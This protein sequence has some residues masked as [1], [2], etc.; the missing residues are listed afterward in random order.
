MPPDRQPRDDN[1]LFIDC[2]PLG[3]RPRHHYQ[4]GDTRHIDIVLSSLGIFPPQGWKL[5]VRLSLSGQYLRIFPMAFLR[6][7]RRLLMTAL[8]MIIR[9]RIVIQTY[10]KT[11]LMTRPPR[12]PLCYVLG[13]DHPGVLDT[14]D[15]KLQILLSVCVRQ[16][17]KI[18]S[19]L[20]NCP[21]TL[22]KLT[23]CLG[24]VGLAGLHSFWDF[25]EAALCP[26]VA[27]FKGVRT[28]RGPDRLPSNASPEA[29]QAAGLPPAHEGSPG[30]REP[31]Q[32][33]PPSLHA[34]PPTQEELAAQ[35][36]PFQAT[37][38]VLAPS[39]SSEIVKI[40]LSAPCTVNQ[41]LDAVELGRPDARQDL[42]GELTPVLPQ[43]FEDHAV[44]IAAP[45]WSLTTRVVCLHIDFPQPRLFSV[46]VPHRL[47]RESICLLAECPLGID[48]CVYV[49]NSWLA[50]RQGEFALFNHGDLVTLAP[51]NIL[52]RPGVDLQTML[53]S[54]RPWAANP[55]VVLGPPGCHFNIL[56]D[57][58]PVRL[59]LTDFGRQAF[60]G[61][62]ETALQADPLRLSLI[63]PLPAIEDFMHKGFHCERTVL[64]TE[65]ISRIPVPPG[66]VQPRRTAFFI[67]GRPLLLG[68]FWRFAPG[69]Q[70]DVT[71]LIEE[72]AHRVS[73]PFV[74][75]VTGGTPMHYVD[76]T[77]HHIC[78]GQVV[79]LTP[80]CPA[81]NDE[82]SS[83]PLLSDG[84]E[85]SSS[86]SSGHSSPSSPSEHTQRTDN[87]AAPDDPSAAGSES[88]RSPGRSAEDRSRSP[89][90][91]G[92]GGEWHLLTSWLCL[93][94][95]LWLAAAPLTTTWPYMCNG[96]FLHDVFREDELLRT[97]VDQFFVLCAGLAYHLAALAR[98]LSST[99]SVVCAL[100][101]AIQLGCVRPGTIRSFPSLGFAVGVFLAFSVACEAVQLGASRGGVPDLAHPEPARL[102]PHL[103]IAVEARVD[104]DLSSLCRPTV[105]KARP[106]PTPCRSTADPPETA[107]HAAYFT[108]ADDSESEAEEDEAPR[109][110]TPTPDGPD[111]LDCTLDGPS[112][113]EWEIFGRAPV[114]SR[115]SSLSS[116]TLL[117]LAAARADCFA[118]ALASA[119]L[120]VLCEA[121]PPTCWQADVVCASSPGALPTAVRPGRILTL[122]DKLPAS[123]LSRSPFQ[124]TAW[125]AR[126]K[127]CV[128]DLDGT[129]RVGNVPVPF[130]WRQFAQLFAAGADLVDLTTA[131]A[132]CPALRQWSRPGL[133]A[134]LSSACQAF[135]PDDIVCFTDGSYTAVAEG[136][137]LCG[138]ACVLFHTG[139]Q[140]LR[141]LYGSFPAFLA[142]SD[143]CPSPFQGEAAGLLAAALATTATAAY[144]S[145]HFLSDCI[146]ALGIAE[147]VCHSAPGSVAQAMR[148]AHWLR[149]QCTPGTDSYSH[150]RGHQ[151]HIG[152]EVADLLAKAAAS[153]ATPSCGLRTPTH[154]LCAWLGAGAPYLPWAGLAILSATG[155]S[156]LPPC[157]AT[158][159]GNDQDHA[160]LTCCALLEPFIP[161]GAIPDSEDFAGHPK[162]PDVAASPGSWTMSLALATFNTLSLGSSAEQEGTP[163]AVTEGLA[164][165]PARAVLLA[166]QLIDHGIHVACL[167][168]TRAEAGLTK[169]GGFLRFASGAIRGQWG[170]EWWF[171]E[172]HPLGLQS[173]DSPTFR[174]KHFAVVF[175][176]ARRLFV[177][178]VC[179]PIRILFIGVHAP[180]RATEA[181]ALLSWW[182]QT[183]KL[184]KTHCRDE[185]VVFAGDCNAA[186][187]SIGSNHIGPH[188]AEPE[189][190]AGEQLHDILRYI[191]GCLPASIPELHSGPTHTYT[192]KR[193]GGLARIDYL[194]VPRSWLR[195]CCKS[196][197]APGIHAAHSCPDHVAL[198]LHIQLPIQGPSAVPALR[199]R[200]FCASDILAPA[201]ADALA[202][203]LSA[204]PPVPWNI[205][206]HAHAAILVSCV[207]R[208]LTNLKQKSGPRQHRS[209]LKP[210][211]W[212]LQRQVASA[213]G[214]LHRLQHQLRSQRLAV[215]FD[216][217]CG[218]RDASAPH[219]GAAWWKQADVAIAAHQAVLRQWC[220]Q[221]RLACRNDRADH[222]SQL[223]DKISTGPSGEIF[224]NLHAL[225]SHKRRKP[226][227]AEPLPA[228]RLE[229]GTLCA[230]GDQVLARWRRHF[231]GLEAGIELSVPALVD[232]VHQ[233]IHEDNADSSPWP[234]PE[235]LLDLPT[236]AD[237]QRLLVQAKANKAPGADGLPSELGRQFSRQLAP[238]LH[239]LALKTAL[240]GCEPIGFKS[241]KAVWFFKGKGSMS[242]CSS[243][244]AILLLPVW[245]KILHQSLR[246]PLKSHFQANSPELQLGGKSGISVVFGSHLI[247]GAA[248]YAASQGRTH[249]TLFT[250]IASAF[251]TVIQQLVAR[252]GSQTVDASAFRQTTQGLRLS[253]EE[254]EALRQH[255]AAPTAMSS[256]GASPWL[257]ALTSRYQA[258]N[259]FMLKGDDKVVE[260]SRGSRP[261]SSW[262]DLVFAEVITRVLHRRDALRDA[263]F[264][265]SEPVR[266]PWDGER[267]LD[268]VPPS[269]ADLSLDNVVWAD[270]VA[271]PRLT[272]PAQAA[273][274]LAF[275]TSCLVDSFKEFGFSLAFGP[276][277]TA[278]VLHLLGAGSRTAK[279]HIFGS[280]GLAGAVPVVF[281]NG[282]VRLPL[283]HSYRHLGTQQ[284]PGGGLSAEIRYRI[285][286][287]RAS[288]AEGRRKVYKVSQISA[289]RKSHILCAT[290]LAKLFHGA[291]SWGPLSQCERRLLQ[292][293]LWSFYRP[294]LGIKHSDD[295]HVDTFSCL[296]LLELPSLDT[297]M[298]FHRLTYFRQVVSSAPPAVW[299]VLR[300][301]RAH[302]SLV[303]EETQLNAEQAGEETATQLLGLAPELRQSLVHGCS[304]SSL[305]LAESAAKFDVFVVSMF[306]ETSTMHRCFTVS[307]SVWDEVCIPC[308]RAFANRT[309]FARLAGSASLRLDA[310]GDICSPTPT[311]FPSGVLFSLEELGLG[312]RTD[313]SLGLL[314]ELSA[315][316][317]PSSGLVWDIVAGYVEP[318]TVLRATVQEWS[319][320]PEATPD[321]VSVC[322][323]ILLL[324]D[325]DLLADS[326]QPLTA[327]GRTISE[328]V[329]DW[330]LPGAGPLVC[331]LPRQAFLLATPPS[332]HLSP[333]TPRSMRLRDATGYAVW[334]ED[335]CRVLASLVEASQVR[336][337]NLHC[338]GIGD[339]LGPAA[340]WMRAVGF[341]VGPDDISTPV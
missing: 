279:R 249:F 171:R 217:W 324:L 100:C 131:S 45:I 141:F 291:G 302:A 296:A 338:P 205:S 97:S 203:G 127:S 331:G 169:V 233:G 170:T 84:E 66:R 266:L 232:R 192:H 244:R 29:R 82:V 333:W 286:Q 189:D 96:A 234:L 159:L 218:R 241:G 115:H 33:P 177:R 56:T 246:P 3:E 242:D 37:I 102:S 105:P 191:D 20:E 121:F 158:N 227:R 301:D 101:I 320:A 226:Y 59:T 311:A 260:T 21:L 28:H 51:A 78:S 6:M 83:P 68:L 318:L 188:G 157:N 176:D 220:A 304:C 147:G 116:C 140:S 181:E 120:E 132:F 280:S 103:A 164:F 58:M 259:F 136:P 70:V 90:S 110:D 237:I 323:D 269:S 326:R 91:R 148:H 186:V 19:Q 221:L 240:R 17:I 315:V 183:F 310:Y 308:R 287:A 209:Y 55:D 88:P 231:G 50:L 247:R 294:L 145:V 138:W 34:T 289:R 60:T 207:Q 314:A 87:N 53:L 39:Y 25:A 72:F 64:A 223:A 225:L 73:P 173:Q 107:G 317:E 174:E 334:L 108:I 278:G 162:A 180:H 41:A 193:G 307:P 292:G 215:C 89:R 154:I 224:Q 290:V 306:G 299:A 235:S 16:S 111:D 274:A 30:Q 126:L 11:Q 49:G 95:H 252:S 228:L 187:G 184:V 166:S 265:C 71:A 135:P 275:E 74:L 175:S 47:N 122:D 255:L 206:G 139:S 144:A 219:C 52:H 312:I 155:D 75:T 327:P 236:E 329:P 212:Q 185:W 150:I 270:D 340:D 35:A 113:L 62:V 243:Y 57:A 36:E 194:C 94:G 313:V 152:N 98:L 8:I 204:L 335:A 163:C 254:L 18:Y 258:D 133:I 261:G 210:E 263:G 81:D 146:S 67:D 248:R 262:A 128:E 285:A 264:S 300:A 80:I 330:P 32:R 92:L 198:A 167:Q 31:L 339:A 129:I 123:L 222:I 282:S 153:K 245:G 253:S 271:L 316:E 276:H 267:T 124:P 341:E 199:P 48:I 9:H 325:V 273:S 336:P 202:K 277:K 156:S 190:V 5:V 172:N 79:V 143:F 295:Q 109:N 272:T 2:R 117:W 337:G 208:I 160:G 69:Q 250:D 93:I 238:H 12:L 40:G 85:S 10:Q 63:A 332:M 284:S 182:Q 149:S 112:V 328:S 65:Q 42:F 256:S 200:S 251:Y 4:I 114:H 229:D 179:K 195:G 44:L 43:P 125:E 211:T 165:R 257:E 38:V 281:E 15:V 319:A 283:V 214:S 22:S 303:Q 196:H 76:R 26:F 106:V 298:R 134:A 99:A 268:P 54:A 197:L 7:T 297:W 77:I 168:E 1:V 293:A 151:G 321:R 130:T 13:A 216:S 137:D 23:C 14:P 305:S 178:F 46:T 104:S 118:F 161:Q 142:E 201:N 239:R 27:G 230:D 322:Q 309:R 119:T 213:R 61:H 288:F 86:G 24:T